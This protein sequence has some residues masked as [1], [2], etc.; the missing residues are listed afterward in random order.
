M[1]FLNKLKEI[2]KVFKYNVETIQLFKV[3]PSPN[4]FFFTIFSSWFVAGFV[5]RMRAPLIGTVIN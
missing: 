3:L 2:L 4:F 5:F 1:Y